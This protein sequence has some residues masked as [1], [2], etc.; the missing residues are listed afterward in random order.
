MRILAGDIGGTNTR[1]AFV[2]D[3]SSARLR[4]EKI[5]ASAYYASL[6]SIIEDFLTLYD[7]QEQLDAC[8]LAVAG[9]VIS[10]CAVL[11]NLPWKI[12]EQELATLLQTERVTLINDLVAAAYAIPDLKTDELLVLQEGNNKPALEARRDAVI[13]AAGTGL[14]A[15]HLVWQGDHYQAF[16]SEAGHAGFAPQTKVQRQLLA[17]L[18]PQYGHVSAEMLLSGMG[19]HTIYRFHA[20]VMGLPES[21]DVRASMRTTD[22][23]RVIT[24]HALA[25]SDELCVQT[26]KC[27]IEIYGS[28]T[29][30]ITLHYFPVNAVYLA[31][32]IAQKIKT[33]LACPAFI[34]AFTNKGPM[35]DNLQG[36]PVYLVLTEHPGL[37]GAIVHARQ[38]YLQAR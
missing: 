8:C 20:E 5:Y 10:G 21:E 2:Q 15:S 3:D 19:L 33:A 24:R 4:H 11:T 34:H 38:F 18:Q 25:A 1:L 12:C 14:G 32:G 37:E 28:V 9:P 35:H 27:F 13:V 17:W 22:P 30:D 16:S 31:G 29:A 7:I 6:I 26:V 36:L 23:A